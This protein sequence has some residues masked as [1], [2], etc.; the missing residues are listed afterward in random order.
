MP[1][2]FRNQEAVAKPVLKNEEMKQLR[3]P[4]VMSDQTLP[5]KKIMVAALFSHLKAIPFSLT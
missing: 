3:R 2:A 1:P 5:T 4:A